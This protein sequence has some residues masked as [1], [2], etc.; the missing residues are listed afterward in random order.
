MQLQQRDNTIKRL[1]KQLNTHRYK[2]DDLEEDLAVQLQKT[3]KLGE[4]NVM[5]FNT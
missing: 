2:A 5:S 4:P 3:E 1:Q